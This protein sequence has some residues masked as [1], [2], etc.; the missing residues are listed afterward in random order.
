MRLQEEE[1]TLAREAKKLANTKTKLLK[2]KMRENREIKALCSLQENQLAEMQNKLHDIT[3]E[4]NNTKME[5]NDA[6]AQ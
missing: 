6:T 4:L 1:A 3:D 2:E 5:V